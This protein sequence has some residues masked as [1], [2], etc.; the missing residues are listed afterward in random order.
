MWRHT[1][2]GEIAGNEKIT[3]EDICRAIALAT[4]HEIDEG[5]YSNCLDL[6]NLITTYGLDI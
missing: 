1:D 2:I 3:Y 6:L 5:H 4:L